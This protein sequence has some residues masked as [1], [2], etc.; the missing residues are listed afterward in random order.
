MQIC[1][2][3]NVTN[4]VT[5]Y[6]RMVTIHIWELW[7]LCGLDQKPWSVFVLVKL[8]NRLDVQCIS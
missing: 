5:V 6:I 1:Y 7:E 3:V 2:N 4:S 8:L